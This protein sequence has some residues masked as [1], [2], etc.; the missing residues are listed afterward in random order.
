MK[1]ESLSLCEPLLRSVQDAG[2]QN[3][4]P[5]QQK[6]IPPILKGRD[7]IGC[8]QT[9]T[10]KTAAFTL[11]TLQ[12]LI[13]SS[14]KTSENHS[15]RSPSQRRIIRCL[16][17][18]PT[19][20]LAGQIGESLA[21]YGRFSELRQTVIFG[22]VKQGPQVRALQAGIDILVATPGRLLDLIGQG[23][24]KLSDVQILIL[25]ESDQML[26]MG[27]IQDLRK[28]VSQIPKQRQTLMFS[29]TMPPEIRKL[30]QQW[31]RRPIEIQ[32]TPIASTPEHVSQSVY[33]VERHHK[34]ETLRRFL[35]ET[36]HS[37]TLVFSRTRR[38]ADKI[39]SCLKRDG[40][41]AVA[42]HGEKSQG[43]RREVMKEFNSKRPPVLVATDLAARG[44]DFTDIS[45]VINFDLPE[46]PESYVHRI[47]RTA[48][49]GASGHAVSFC[50]P[51]E[52]NRLRLIEKLIGQALSVKTLPDLPASEISDN[53][54]SQATQQK[55]S[56]TQTIT[57]IRT[58]SRQT[59][60]PKSRKRPS[61][62]NSKPTDRAS[63]S[64][65]K[66]ESKRRKFNKVSKKKQ[67]ARSHVTDS[68]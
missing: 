44:L 66:T 9:G 29:A 31:L 4:T 27:F 2:Y 41:R 48:R 68:S 35:Q 14:A 15:K 65:A 5:I 62:Q 24:V 38:G 10:G 59:R 28:I 51:D 17:L 11:P 8:A 64:R 25:D 33:F 61:K 42:I 55:G 22:G 36:K 21:T 54:P 43:R 18:A 19:R 26:D 50:L 40:I 20:E 60:S 67:P 13:S 6:A 52:R 47:G 37:K 32:V 1:F 53:I 23:F 58:G 45:H 46:A 39:A 7:L 34:A 49:A 12:Q 16:I 57:S 56:D 30:S 3:A 63:S